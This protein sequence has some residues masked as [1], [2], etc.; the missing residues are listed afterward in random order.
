[1]AMPINAIFDS[2][3]LDYSPLGENLRF[4]GPIVLGLS[5]VILYC[6]FLTVL[7]QLISF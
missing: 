6:V 4:S 7:I 3:A 1:M 2:P 5:G